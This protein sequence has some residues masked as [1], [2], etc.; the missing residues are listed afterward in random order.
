[1][2]KFIMTTTAVLAF[3][4]ATQLR[5]EAHP[6]QFCF[7]DRLSAPREIVTS[8]PVTVSGLERPSEL[9]IQGRGVY[10]LNGHRMGRKEHLVKNGDR[11]RLQQK[12]LPQDEAKVSTTLLIGD[13]YDIFTV[14]TSKE[15]SE[16]N[17]NINDAQEGR[18]CRI[19]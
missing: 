15:A 11:I 2:K 18:S 12:A 8:N 4:A 5:A 1:M 9:K 3:I 13:V 6:D 7:Q 14:E 17:G 16:G 19:H 10:I